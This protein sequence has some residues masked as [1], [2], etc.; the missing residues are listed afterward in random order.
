MQGFPHGAQDP[1]GGI[2]GQA[3][4]FCGSDL[5]RC[6]PIVKMAFHQLRSS[7]YQSEQLTCVT[8]AGIGSQHFLQIRECP[9]ISGHDTPYRLKGENNIVRQSGTHLARTTGR[10]FYSQAR[11]KTVS[12]GDLCGLLPHL[13]EN[14]GPFS[15]VLIE[16][17]STPHRIHRCI[18][19]PTG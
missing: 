1:I 14:G 19:V 5:G 2:A 3:Q 8:A 6:M 12:L 4:L 15:G 7:F 11:G 10:R 13:L 9:D 16:T 17:A 18:C